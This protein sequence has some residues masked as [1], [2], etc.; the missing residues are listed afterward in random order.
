MWCL[1][2]GGGAT[3]AEQQATL[4]DAVEDRALLLVRGGAPAADF[5]NA[6]L[7]SDA[8][9]LLIQQ[10]NAIAGRG[11]GHDRRAVRDGELCKK[12]KATYQCRYAR[13]DA[14]CESAG[15]DRESLH[16]C[17]EADER[18]RVSNRSVGDQGG[19]LLAR[20]DPVFDLLGRLTLGRP[21]G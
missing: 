7:A 14:R 20:H 6:A 21:G 9:L 5:I 11:L 2:S 16:Q 15:S 8:N 3:V 1:G 4:R 18:F 12:I 19:D 17:V 13:S 10:A